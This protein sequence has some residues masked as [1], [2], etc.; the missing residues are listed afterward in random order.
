MGEDEP[1]AGAGNVALVAYGVIGGIYALWTVGWVLGAMRLRA[2]IEGA[3]GAVADFMFLGSM[4]LAVA[5]PVVWFL[6]AIVGT[7]GKRPWQRF[8]W[9]GLGVL[10]LVPWPFVMVGVLGQ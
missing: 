2:R 6:V 9:L 8:L 5:A 4:V 7:R 10:L 3:T 1:P